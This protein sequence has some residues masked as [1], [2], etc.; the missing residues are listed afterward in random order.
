[1]SKRRSVSNEPVHDDFIRLENPEA[2]RLIRQTPEILRT[3]QDVHRLLQAKQK[4]HLTVGEFA[5]LVSRAPF[6][7]RTWLKQGR[8]K[9]TRIAGT[10]PRGRLLIARDQLP[11]LVEAGLASGLREPIL[12]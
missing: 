11:K 6:T 4:E 1:M 12:D 3:V 2:E 10:G 8:T 7:V 9:A 5:E